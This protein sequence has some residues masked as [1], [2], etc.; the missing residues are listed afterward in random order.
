MCRRL[1]Q[2]RADLL[3]IEI[4]GD[5]PETNDIKL[6]SLCSHTRFLLFKQ[7]SGGGPSV[8]ASA[9]SMWTVWE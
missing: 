8:G 2:P 5:A 1:L 4:D 7:N 6:F 9:G 3:S